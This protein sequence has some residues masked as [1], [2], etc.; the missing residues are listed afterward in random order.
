MLQAYPPMP[1]Q[2]SGDRTDD[3]ERTHSAVSRMKLVS[4]DAGEQD[5]VLLPALERVDASHLD[6]GVERRSKRSSPLQMV[7]EVRPLPFVRGHDL[8][9]HARVT[10]EADLKR[11]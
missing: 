10:S 2:I 4:P 3:T 5:D 11:V 1:S 9:S 7:D 8:A 6:L